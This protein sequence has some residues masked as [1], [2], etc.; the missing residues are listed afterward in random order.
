M[1]S[2]ITVNLECRL[3]VIPAGTGYTS[4]GFEVAEHRRAAVLS[5]ATGKAATPAGNL[6]ALEH[7][8]AYSDAMAQGQRHFAATGQRCPAELTP[9]LIGLEGKRVEVREPHGGEKRRFWVGKSTGWMPC[10]L[11]IKTKRSHG[12][13]CVWF[14][15]GSTVTVIR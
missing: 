8:Q 2:K 5:W 3:Y 14:P 1:E 11:E 12:G 4:L 6:G 7:Y 13:G 15:E 10:H 9:A